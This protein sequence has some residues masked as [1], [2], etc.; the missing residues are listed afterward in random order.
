M[1]FE[2]QSIKQFEQI[3]KAINACRGISGGLREQQ[4]RSGGLK[5]G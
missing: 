2:K 3:W 4:L 5:K 1:V